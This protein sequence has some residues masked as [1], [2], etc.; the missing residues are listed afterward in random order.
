MRPDRER[1]LQELPGW[2]WNPHVDRWEK[3]FRRLMDYVERHG[4]ARTPQSYT[5]DGYPLGRWVSC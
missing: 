4:D 2:L 1:R 3:D 5:V